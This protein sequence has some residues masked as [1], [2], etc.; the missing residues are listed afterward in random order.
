L[1][2]FFVRA[3]EFP[4]GPKHG[5]AHSVRRPREIAADHKAAAEAV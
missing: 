3:G 5:Y 2:D 4:A 1:P